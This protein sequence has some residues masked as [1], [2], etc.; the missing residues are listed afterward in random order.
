[1]NREGRDPGP[2]ERLWEAPEQFLLDAGTEGELLIARIRVGLTCFLLL[3]PVVN[4]LGAD[5]SEWQHHL[6]GLAVTGAACAL[7]IGIWW[8]VSL[9]RRQRW[10]PM[11]TS[12]FDIT[13][14]SLAQLSF[15][16]VSDPQVVVNS[17]ITFDT[18]FIALAATCLRYDRRVALVAGVVA[19]AQ[20]SATIAWVASAFPLDTVGGVSV[21]GRFQWSDQ[22]SRLV[23]LAAATVLN[24]YIVHGIQ[25]QRKLSNADPLTGVFNR[26][27]FDDYLGSEVARAARYHRPLAVAMI[28]V[29]HFK[30]FND[31]FGHAAGDAALR[32]VARTLALSV[33]RSDL[34]ARY[35]GEE[36]VVILRETGPEQALERMELIR[37]EVARQAVLRVGQESIRVTVSIGVAGWPMDGENPM[38]LLAEADRRLFGAKGAGRNRVVGRG[39]TRSQAEGVLA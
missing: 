19:I 4:L 25:K 24:V 27:F 1:M 31:R 17:K 28:D 38:D 37:E 22:V 11:A 14:I 16:F 18:Y 29:D 7:S 23:L 5:R 34:V 21:Y 10:L 39:A 8:L 32:S 36:F 12:L 30:Q 6:V 3:V 20:F 26:R 35:G 15:A 13:F 2:F 9:D 33:R